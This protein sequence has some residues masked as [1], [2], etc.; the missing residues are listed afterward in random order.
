VSDRGT[1]N[2]NSR[3]SAEARRARKHFLLDAF[4]DGTWVPCSFC[5]GVLD[6]GTLTVDR[7]VPGCQ[8]GTY[9]RDNIRP[10]CVTCNSLDGTAWRERLKLARIA[11]MRGPDLLILDDPVSA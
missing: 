2:G 5:R 3:G 6:W 8:G 11:S 4:G 9:A 7:I 1:T 10:A